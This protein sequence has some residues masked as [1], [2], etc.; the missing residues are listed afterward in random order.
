MGGMLL[1]NL[2]E[3]F[4]QRPIAKKYCEGKL[5]STLEIGV[6]LGHEMKEREQKGC[7]FLKRDLK[8]FE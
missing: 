8:K 5:K 1:P 3:I 7:N 2:I 6:K 4:K